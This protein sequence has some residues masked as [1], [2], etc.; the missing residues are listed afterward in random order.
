M[1]K[2]KL[3]KQAV[4]FIDNLPTKQQRQ[5]A[6]ALLS[7]Q[8]NIQPQDSKKLQGYD[9]Y[10]IDSGEYRIIYNWDSECISVYIIGKRNDSDVYRKLQRKFK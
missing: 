10:R 6:T 9:Y 4:K 1:Y 5:I 3:H 8:K 7:L 2:I